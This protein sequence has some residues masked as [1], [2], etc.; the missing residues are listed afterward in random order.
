MY[1]VLFIGE[2]WMIHTQETKG[3][4][5]FTY[6]RYEE[7]T[8]YIKAALT[9]N[10]FAEF[11]HIP[12]HRVDLD[13]PR[14][15]EEL[16][17][18]DAVMVSDCGANTFNLPMDTFVALKKCPNKLH[19]IREYVRRG[20]AFVM[21]G[22]YLTFQGIQARGAYKDTA[23]EEILPVNLLV[24]DDRRENCQGVR[25]VPTMP[26]H[27][28]FKGLPEGEWP[29]VLG[30]NKLLPKQ[31]AQGVLF[32]QGGKMTPLVEVAATGTRVWESS[33]GSGTVALAWYL[34]QN[35]ADGMHAFAFDEPGGR[36]E[37]RV[38]MRAG[39]AA[40]IEMGGA[41]KLGEE[42]EIEL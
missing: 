22:G 18:Y 7:A 31:D 37:A 38:A 6:D 32:V 11:T 42:A 10:G 14:T 41:V 36:L 1:R 5:V 16:S 2:S 15:V 28:I 30:Y 13:F 4:D 17:A 9:E 21:I 35:L 19:M 23:I 3:F 34:A 24:G 25:P 8:E 26:E 27:P 40:Q 20:G 33:C 12:S 29:E 39:R